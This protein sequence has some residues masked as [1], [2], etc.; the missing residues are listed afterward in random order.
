[1]P[2]TRRELI[3]DAAV[4]AGAGAAAIRSTEVGAEPDDKTIPKRV[5]GRT[6]KQVSLIGFGM[7]PLGSDNTTPDQ[8]TEILNHA[9]D[10]GINYLD[11]APIYGND[12]QKYGNA[13]SK[14]KATLAKRRG[15]VLLT[16]K[17]NAQRPDRDGVLKQLEESLKRLGVD[18]VDAAHIHN[19]AD[20]DEDKVFYQGGALDGLL[21]AK[22]RGLIKYIGVSG[23]QR[24][25]RFNAAFFTGQFDIMMVPLNFADWVNYDFPKFAL[26][27]ATKRNVGVLAMKVLGGAKDWKYD[28]RTP[29][30]LAAYHEKAIRYTLGIPGVACAVIGLSTK[31]EVTKAVEVAR[32]YQPLPARELE[33][34]LVA[35]K[36]LAVERGAYYGPVGK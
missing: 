23:H 30:S 25:G 20:F 27:E 33:D 16:T 1:M 10:L 2:L 19:L 21:E 22:K 32:N 5:L 28:S 26:L 29:G 36:R 13:E 7:A 4:M 35:G 12:Q 31:D 18:Q 17:V 24:P 15:E 14:M 11:V 8:A 34:L 3:Q 9:L 6:G